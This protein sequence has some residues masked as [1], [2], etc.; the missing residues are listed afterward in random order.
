MAKHLEGKTSLLWE[1]PK[2]CQW[3]N[4]RKSL[5]YQKE[6]R[7]QPMAD[8][9]SVAFYN[10]QYFSMNEIFNQKIHRDKECL[11]FI[12]YISAGRYQLLVK[13]STNRL[14]VGYEKRQIRELF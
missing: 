7:N 10:E 11:E 8:V 4:F 1:T 14:K 6:D 2:Q 5:S 12:I 3:K 9:Y 13:T